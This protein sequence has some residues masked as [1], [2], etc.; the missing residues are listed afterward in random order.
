[1]QLFL[2]SV[3][4]SDE[5]RGVQPPKHTTLFS[6]GYLW[7]TSAQISKCLHPSCTYVWLSEEVLK[8]INEVPPAYRIRIFKDVELNS[9]PPRAMAQRSSPKSPSLRSWGRLRMDPAPAPGLHTVPATTDAWIHRLRKN[10]GNTNS[11][12]HTGMIPIADDEK[13]IT[14]NKTSKYEL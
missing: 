11:L 14:G 10:S 12:W 6:P 8:L 5:H 1:M 3:S 9:G 2:T 7:F 13:M 4:P